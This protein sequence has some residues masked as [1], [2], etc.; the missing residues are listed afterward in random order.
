MKRGVKMIA[1]G[2]LYV[3]LTACAF[4]LVYMFNESEG[5][6]IARIEN[7]LTDL[8]TQ[9]TAVPRLEKQQDVLAMTTTETAKKTNDLAL[10]VEK[11]Q[12]HCAMLGKEHRHLQD[13]V[14]KKKPIL[15]FSG[16]LQVE[17]L[18]GKP[19]F[20]PPKHLG[21]KKTLK[22]EAKKETP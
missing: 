5:E 20:T 13:E 8:V 16:P 18:S 3:G 10:E 4:A 19:P 9:M 14:G 15:G 7:R 17:I 6:K 22:P 21:K 11:L 2:V 12:E 1:Y